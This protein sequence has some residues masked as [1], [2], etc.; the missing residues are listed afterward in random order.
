MFSSLYNKKHILPGTI[1][2][3]NKR[4]QDL[5]L[6][7]YIIIIIGSVAAGFIDSIAGGG[8][9]ITIPILLAVGLPP[10]LALGT[11]KLQAAFGS[12]TSTL[13]YNKSGLID[14]KKIW[15]GIIFTFIGAM[16]GTLLIQNISGDFLEK[17]VP[18]LLG[19][20]FLYTLFKKDLGHIEKHKRMNTLPFFAIFGILIG[21]YDGFFGP[22]TGSFWTIAFVTVM[23]MNIKGGTGSSKPM[24]FVSNI[25]ALIFFILGKN[26]IFHIGFIMAVGQIIG[27]LIGSHIVIKSNPK[28]IRHAL[29]IIIG[30]TIINTFRQ[31]Y[32]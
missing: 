16:V 1:F 6:I 26:I 14:F 30:I 9:M 15:P 20:I 25:T 24:N 13:R 28:F 27:S 7:S 21:F 29:L 5:T 23:G 12:L 11:N 19:I 17:A 31:F 4:M 3:Y 10:H 2:L 32:F 22:G 18:I 8:G